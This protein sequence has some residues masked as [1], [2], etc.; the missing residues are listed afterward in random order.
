MQKKIEHLVT[1][2]CSTYWCHQSLLDPATENV[3]ILDINVDSNED[4]SAS[5]YAVEIIY[6]DSH[7]CDPVYDA[8]HDITT[9]SKVANDNTNEIAVN[10]N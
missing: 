7:Q 3:T 8:P 5:L 9:D 10:V 2:I 1:R 6:I 4:S